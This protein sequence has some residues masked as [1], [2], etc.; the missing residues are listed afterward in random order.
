MGKRPSQATGRRRRRSLQEIKRLV[1]ELEASGLSRVGFARRH[2]VSSATVGNWI[3]RVRGD[4]TRKKGTELKKVAPPVEF[5]A[6]DVTEEISQP[7]SPAHRSVPSGKGFELIF[8]S[9]SLSSP[10]GSSSPARSLAWK[11]LRIPQQFDPS[12]LAEV[13]EVLNRIHRRA[14]TEQGAEITR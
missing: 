12:G 11:S 14:S 1:A 3:R 6:V 10:S 4:R 5:L 8:D 13:L 7:R 2:R 9:Q